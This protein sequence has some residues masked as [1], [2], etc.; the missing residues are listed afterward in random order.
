MGFA[1][2][3]ICRRLS[4]RT[5]QHAIFCRRRKK[6]FVKACGKATGHG[7]FVGWRKVGLPKMHADV[8]GKGQSGVAGAEDKRVNIDRNARARTSRAFG[9]LI[10][11][12]ERP[13]V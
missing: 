5:N 4:D 3:G 10:R 7:E 2:N 8:A 6:P 12:M 13:S 9:P 11:K 1:G